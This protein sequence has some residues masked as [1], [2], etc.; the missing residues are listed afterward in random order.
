MSYVIILREKT[1]V[2]A[3]RVLYRNLRYVSFIVYQWMKA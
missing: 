1:H 3:Y 2:H